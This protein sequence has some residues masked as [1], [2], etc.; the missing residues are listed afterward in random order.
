M[1]SINVYPS[2]RPSCMGTPNGI[3]FGIDPRRVETSKLDS[4]VSRIPSV[5]VQMKEYLFKNG[6][7]QQVCQCFDSHQCLLCCAHAPYIHA[8]GGYLSPG[9]GR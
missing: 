9:S 8:I 3:Q 4:Y 5:L 7:L 6:G 1:E 2:I